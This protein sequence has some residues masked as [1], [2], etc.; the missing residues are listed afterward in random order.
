MYVKVD[1]V[2]ASECNCQKVQKSLRA[3][4]G[5]LHDSNRWRWSVFITSS[6]VWSYHTNEIPWEGHTKLVSLPLLNC[7]HPMNY[8]TRNWSCETRSSQPNIPVRAGTARGRWERPAC[9]LS[10][11][12]RGS[13]CVLDYPLH[14][15]VCTF[16][17]TQ[18]QINILSA[19]SVLRWNRV[20]S[21]SCPV[22]LESLLL[23]RKSINCDGWVYHTNRQF[24][25][26]DVM[27]AKCSLSFFSLSH[28]KICDQ[29]ASN[30]R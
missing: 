24:K 9:H 4:D 14:T 25:C 1:K 21:R 23:G 22:N 12:C 20:G 17:G 8:I 10:G 29:D 18:R 30:H 6:W 11:W 28:G 2:S 5:V 7:K 26:Y 16:S 27:T 15:V 3:S 19:V 13:P